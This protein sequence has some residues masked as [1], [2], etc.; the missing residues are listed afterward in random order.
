MRLKKHRED[1]KWLNKWPAVPHMEVIAD[2]FHRMILAMEE[3]IKMQRGFYTDRTK[4]VLK[5]AEGK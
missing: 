1:V 4:R 2:R 5:D 3:T